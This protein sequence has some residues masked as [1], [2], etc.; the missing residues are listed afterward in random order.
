APRIH[1]KGRPEWVFV[2][3][4]CHGL[5]SKKL[6]SS[7][8][9]REMFKRMIDEWNHGEYRLHFVNSRE[10]Y[11]IVKAAENGETG[12]PAAYFDY[13]I[14]APANRRIYCSTPWRLIEYSA[15]Y[16]RI[17]VER[18]AVSTLRI[19]GL[20]FDSIVGPFRQIELRGEDFEF[21]QIR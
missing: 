5:Q 21:R 2:K 7:S 16:V 20:R 13:A 17:A 11:N 6:F 3:L 19:A 15:S 10:A 8:R 18:S 12:N 1:V 4:H 9:I 14:P